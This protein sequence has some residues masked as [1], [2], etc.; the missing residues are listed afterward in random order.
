MSTAFSGRKK[1]VL[2]VAPTPPPV[3]GGAL[4]MQAILDSALAQ[5]FHVLHVNSR[6]ARDL[7]ELQRFSLAKLLLVPKYCWQ[8]FWLCLR[9]RVDGVVL[10]PTM[11]VKPFLKDSVFI[12]L[13]TLVLRRKTAGWF[14]MDWRVM[15]YDKRPPLLRW[16]V[17]MTLR[18]LNAWVLVGDRLRDVYPD[19]VPMEQKIGLANGI[20]APVSPKKLT[21]DDGRVRILYLSNIMTSKGWRDLLDAARVLCAERSE[22]EVIFH[23]V[24]SD[25][26][27]DALRQEIAQEDGGGRIRYAGPVFGESKW[28]ALQQ[29]DL[30]CFPSHHEAFPLTILE[31]MA[32]GLP[33]VATDVGALPDALLDG[34]GGYIV[35]PQNPAALVEKLRQLVARPELRERFGQF[36]RQR[37]LSTY[38]QEAYAQ[39]WGAFLRHWL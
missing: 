27:E 12:W 30:F 37:F 25:L 39:R 16:F 35:P 29:A 9:N 1:C 34:S 20:A 32:A 4:A 26:S 33:I 2:F 38:T 18:R 11:Y 3:H 28:V 24:P 17:R 6:F 15:A 14:H 36:N 7:S 13:C 5:E 23:G 10:T 8:I 31:A 22:V 21:R 19:F